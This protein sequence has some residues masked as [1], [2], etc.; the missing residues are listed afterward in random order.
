MLEVKPVLFPMSTT[1]NLSQFKGEF[2]FFS[3]K[4]SIV[5]SSA[6]YN[7]FISLDLISPMLL[8]YALASHRTLECREKDPTLPK[9]HCTSWATDPPQL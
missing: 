8:V 9:E 7:N 3:M 5:V 2:F 6:L 4:Y 1:A